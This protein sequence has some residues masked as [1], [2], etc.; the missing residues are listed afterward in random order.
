MTYLGRRVWHS[1]RPSVFWIWLGLLGITLQSLTEFGLYIPA[2][3]WP[4]M[5]LLGWL[6]GSTRNDLD[7]RKPTN[8]TSQPK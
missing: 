2:V 6:V 5:A 4:T 1:S 3:S 8:L 7:K